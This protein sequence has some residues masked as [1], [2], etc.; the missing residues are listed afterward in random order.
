MSLSIRKPDLYYNIISI[1]EYTTQDLYVFVSFTT[2][3]CLLSD[4]NCSILCL[5]EQEIIG[6]EIK[7]KGSNLNVHIKWFSHVQY[8]VMQST[9]FS[10]YLEGSAMPGWSVVHLLV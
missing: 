5:K 8:I 4:K 2:Y 9:L 7:L 6:L 10:G 1:S 3:T